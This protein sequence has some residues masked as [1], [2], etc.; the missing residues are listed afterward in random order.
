MADPRFYD[1]VGPFTLADICAKAG[2]A[3]PDG[4]ASTALVEDV[5]S[6]TGA[7]AAHLSF[8]AGGADAAKQFAVTV[9]GYCFVASSATGG[10]PASCLPIPCASVQLAFAE[11]AGA[12]YPQSGLAQWT[13]KTAIDPSAVIGEG[14]SLAPGVVIG[15]HAE[16]G[17][18]TR[19]GPNT[20]IG[21]GVAIGHDCEIGSNVT[22]THAYVGDGALILSGAQIGGPGFGFASSQ[23]GHFKVPQL[24]RVIL[25][26]RVEIGA[27][28]AID[29][30]ALGD[31]V[32]GEGT[33]IDNLVQIGHNT[34]IGRHTVIVGHVGISGSCEIGDFVVVGGQVGIAD[35]SRVGD[36]ARLAGRAGV[37]GYLPG[38]QD[39]GGMPAKPMREYARELAAVK[40]LARGKKKS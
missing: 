17:D 31:T 18:R 7:G 38:G 30:G 24:G 12:F 6:L 21:R 14:I 27:C 1:N 8:Y 16:I 19:I 4:A 34:R 37:V 40:M 11:A 2:V 20:V 3:V 26:D 28:T 29:R 25:Q 22:I 36:G 9:A 10:G 13:Q 35:H 32:I 23:K 39:Y 15:P 5:A 33:K